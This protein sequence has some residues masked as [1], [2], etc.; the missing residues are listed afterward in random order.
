MNRQCF[1]IFL[2]VFH[3]RKSVAKNS[4]AGIGKSLWD[5]FFAAL[6]CVGNKTTRL[7]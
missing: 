7:P 6:L 2:S 5:Y 3:P 1:V 4:P